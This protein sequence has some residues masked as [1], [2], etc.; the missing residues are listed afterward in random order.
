MNVSGV[1]EYR[2][3]CL[4]YKPRNAM[5]HHVVVKTT[6]IC[7]SL[8]WSPKTYHLMPNNNISTCWKSTYIMTNVPC[9]LF[10]VHK[11]YYV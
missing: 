11:S 4:S 2:L 6:E 1:W 10:Y 9:S 7:C 3:H 5:P 8:E